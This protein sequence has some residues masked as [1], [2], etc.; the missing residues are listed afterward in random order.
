MLARVSALPCQRTRNPLPNTC[1]PTTPRPPSAICGVHRRYHLKPPIS[2]L[3]HLHHLPRP[4]RP[5]RRRRPIPLLEPQQWPPSP[6]PSPSTFHLS[7]A[8]GT[9]PPSSLLHLPL[10]SIH[11]RV[12]HEYYRRRRRTTGTPK[13]R[14]LTRFCHD[15]RQERQR[16]ARRQGPARSR[17]RLHLKYVSLP[18]IR[19]L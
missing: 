13:G 4:P 16:R 14:L 5:P 2:S 10:H 9:L 6:E 11:H 19:H 3:R 7:T 15:I 18:A 17:R 1:T 12:Q 8:A